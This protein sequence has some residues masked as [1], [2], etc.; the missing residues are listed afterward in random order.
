MVMLEIIKFWL[1]K[2]Y[3]KEWRKKYEM[4]ENIEKEICEYIR[5]LI[6]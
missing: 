3:N 4:F 1:N 2:K 6:F 5:E